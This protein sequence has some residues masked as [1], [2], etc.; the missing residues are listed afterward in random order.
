[1]PSGD[2]VNTTLT[3][4][5]SGF[6]DAY[7][8]VFGAPCVNISESTI[9]YRRRILFPGGGPRQTPPV[10]EQA[11]ESGLGARRWL[12]APAQRTTNC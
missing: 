1:M 4:A 3:G 2:H 12:K 10:T 6:P 5:I 7:Q 11:P 9:R 8:I